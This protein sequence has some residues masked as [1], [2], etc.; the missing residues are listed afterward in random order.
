MTDGIIELDSPVAVALGFTS[1]KFGGY[2]WKKG[3]TITISFI[4]SLTP[5]RGDFSTLIKNMLSAGYRIVVPTPLAQMEQI[6]KKWGFR[7][8][9]VLDPD[10]GNVEVWTSD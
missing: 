7:P 9:L 1:D 10:M 8:S 6:L 2:L 3:S 4:S 5:G